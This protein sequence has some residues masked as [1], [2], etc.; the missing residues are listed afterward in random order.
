MGYMK[1]GNMNKKI[2]YSLVTALVL[3]FS[4]S[5]HAS[6]V[7]MT[8]LG[9]T[10]YVYDTQ[11]GLDWLKLTD[12]RTIGQSFNQVSALTGTGGPLEG[13]AYA[14]GIQFYTMVSNFTGVTV[15]S[16]HTTDSTIINSYIELFGSTFDEYV[17]TLGY[18][19]Y[20]DQVNSDPGYVAYEFNATR[21][22]LGDAIASLSGHW[23]ASV[24]TDRVL[25]VSYGL[26]T[27]NHFFDAHDTWAPENRPNASVSSYLVRQ[28]Q[29]AVPE[30]SAILLLCIGLVGLG[31]AYRRAK[32][33]DHQHI[34]LDRTSAS[35]N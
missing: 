11:T 5:A 14:S 10:D 27:D 35:S 16:R 8:D 9:G 28:H 23:I 4:I 33:N 1:E 26:V 22:I 2:L 12:S 24:D 15:T 34:L 25:V 7:A 13:W 29:A 19:T 6:L 20:L 3:T 31:F 30:P 32:R 21:G 17:R 18:S